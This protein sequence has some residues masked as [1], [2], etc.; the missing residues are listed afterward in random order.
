MAIVKDDGNIMYSNKSLAR[1]LEQ[2]QQT[3]TSASNFSSVGVKTD[4]SLLSKKILEGVR[5]KKYEVASDFFEKP[6]SS[7]SSYSVWDFIAKNSNGATFQI[8]T[9][10]VT[11][12]NR[13]Q[14]NENQEETKVA[15][16]NLTAN[17]VVIDKQI[18]TTKENTGQTDSII[19]A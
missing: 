9:P 10:P 14:R 16:D 15:L 2:D 1:L 8:T 17:Q 5:I 19:N 6:D 13:L 11:A 4:V 3:N 12:D 7:D 18:I